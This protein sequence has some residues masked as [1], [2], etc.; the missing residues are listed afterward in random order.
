VRSVSR[1]TPSLAVALA[2]A[3]LISIGWVARSTRAQDG[4][5]ASAPV[6][7][8]A[9]PSLAPAPLPQDSAPSA[10]A[11]SAPPQVA[12]STVTGIGAAVVVSS[13]ADP[14]NDDPDQNARAFVERNRKEAQD[15]LKKLKE[16]AE[17]L[18][19]RLGKVEAGIRRWDS[20]LAA[21]DNSERI[22][23]PGSVQPIARD[24][25]TALEPVPAA[26]P[27]TPVRESEP[28]PPKPSDPPV[29]QPM[30]PAEGA[31]PVTR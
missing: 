16:E 7:K 3:G 6:E 31:K 28:S 12:P 2:V 8:A 15:E 20:L 30:P 4:P 22:A 9:E 27:A 29:S 5:K 25:P 1:M 13:P 21:L 24:T 23:P 18:R 11:E 10:P 26:T 14:A 19:T 17:R